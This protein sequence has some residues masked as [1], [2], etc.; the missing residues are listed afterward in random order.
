MAE[1]R[2]TSHKMQSSGD[3]DI[4][5]RSI[6]NSDSTEKQHQRLL[7]LKA[8]LK[9][10]DAGAIAATDF[11]TTG[12]E[13]AQR[14]ARDLALP[15]ARTCDMEGEEVGASLVPDN[16]SGIDNAMVPLLTK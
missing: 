5:S 4:S 11:S 9:V 8:C 1:T 13:T 16:Q 15:S 14:T 6:H 2:A 3:G 12:C 7:T 10:A